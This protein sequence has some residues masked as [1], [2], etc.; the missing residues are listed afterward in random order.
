V[1]VH[2]DVEVDDAVSLA[3]VP[4]TSPNSWRECGRAMLSPRFAN[5]GGL[6]GSSA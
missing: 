5:S 6:L 1:P 2:V 3:N 4:A